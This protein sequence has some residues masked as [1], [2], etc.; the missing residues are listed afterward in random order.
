MYP[1]INI[2]NDCVG[3]AISPQMSKC[4]V[5]DDVLQIGNKAHNVTTVNDRQ[6]VI[7]FSSLWL[8]EKSPL[9]IDRAPLSLS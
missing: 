6:R 1:N 9:A 5:H 8:P 3:D 4:H 2:D 7:F